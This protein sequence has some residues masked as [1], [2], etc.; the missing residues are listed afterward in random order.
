[1]KTNPNEP[2]NCNNGNGFWNDEFNRT[3]GGVG[4]TKR[5]YFAAM[6]MQGLLANSYSNGY[7]QPYSEAS[8]SQLAE[9]AVGQ[10]E[11]LINELNKGI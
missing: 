9:L 10:A 11:A 2:L 3:H 6:A 5:E 1:M 4:L 7:S 8:H